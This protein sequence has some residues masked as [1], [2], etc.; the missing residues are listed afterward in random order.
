[1]LFAFVSRVSDRSCNVCTVKIR[2]LE[3]AYTARMRE[4][5]T[6]VP[7]YQCFAINCAYKLLC[8]LTIYVLQCTD[9]R[10]QGV[11]VVRVRLGP[12]HRMRRDPTHFSWLPT[13]TLRANG[14]CW[15]TVIAIH[16]ECAP[17]EAVL[18]VRGASLSGV[19]TSNVLLCRMIRNILPVPGRIL[20]KQQVEKERCHL[21]QS[22]AVLVRP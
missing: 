3:I 12:S 21:H 19:V 6:Y 8:I 4:S 13:L 20:G 14:L 2:Q 18:L 1:M 7:K 10:S 15:P 17:C 22:V 9:T 5:A 16:L 11:S